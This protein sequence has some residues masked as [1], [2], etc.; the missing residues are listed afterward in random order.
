M[1]PY[2]TITFQLERL[3]KN[4]KKALANIPHLEDIDGWLL[5]VEAVELYNLCKKI[6][7][8]NPIVCEIGSWKGKS[9]YV[10]ASAVRS[11]RG[12]VYSVDPFNGD[13]DAASVEIYKTEMRKLNMPLKE[14]FEKTMERFGL[15]EFV[16]ILPFKSEEAREKFDKNRIDLLFIDGNHEYG[17]VKKDY[18]LWSPLVSPGG[19]IALHDVEAVHIDGPKRVFKE[20]LLGNPIWKNVRIVGEMGVA[21]KN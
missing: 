13:G 2:P 10:F 8:N 1:S 21:E 4:Q 18:D 14:N 9:S 20:C 7:S 3:D 16:K 11:H 17:S 6:C 15:I 5:L 19:F 12:T